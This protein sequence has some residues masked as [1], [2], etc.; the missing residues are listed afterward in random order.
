MSST[1]KI[2]ASELLL[3]FLQAE[4]KITKLDLHSAFRREKVQKDINKTKF[5]DKE[6]NW[7]LGT[8]SP[9]EKHTFTDT[10]S[11]TFT[12]DSDDREFVIVSRVWDKLESVAKYIRDDLA[13]GIWFGTMP[14]GVP[15]YVR[16]VKPAVCV[17]KGNTLEFEITYIKYF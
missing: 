10:C 2:E 9:N 3:I 6:I 5:D 7:V 14:R 11:I 12:V 4:P 15:L 8:E 1:S 13:F 17:Y 16:I